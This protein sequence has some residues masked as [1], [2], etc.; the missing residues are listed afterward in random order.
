MC[1][2]DEELG[3]NGDKFKS[4]D[5]NGIV[6]IEWHIIT[7]SVTTGPKQTENKINH[8]ILL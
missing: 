5:G 1:V 6:N 2:N 4:A 8:N 3:N 7:I